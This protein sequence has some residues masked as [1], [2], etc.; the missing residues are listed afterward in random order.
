MSKELNPNSTKGSSKQGNKKSKENKSKKEEEYN[1]NVETKKM[2]EEVKNKK[3]EFGILFA[4]FF[5]I[6][7]SIYFQYKYEKSLRMSTGD[8][9]D[10]NFYDVLGVDYN[11]DLPTIKKKYKELAKVWYEILF[12]K[13][14]F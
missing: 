4:I 11:A 14:L 12:K 1:F 10:T 9:E 6:V 13:I 3:F 5:I 2:F 8:D 7:L